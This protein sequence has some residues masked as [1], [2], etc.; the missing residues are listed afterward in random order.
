MQKAVAYAFASAITMKI[1]G[2]EAIAFGVENPVDFASA[3]VNHEK[4]LGLEEIVSHVARV[5]GSASVR[6]LPDPMSH[7]TLEP[8]SNAFAE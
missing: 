2:A 7:R 6:V 1:V 5:S 4:F 8:A 3:S